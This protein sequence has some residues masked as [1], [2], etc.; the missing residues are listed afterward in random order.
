[1]G[2]SVDW[3]EGGHYRRVRGVAGLAMRGEEGVLGRRELAAVHQL[4]LLKDVSVPFGYCCVQNSVEVL[5]R[6]CRGDFRV[7]CI[8]PLQKLL[9][10]LVNVT[11]GRQDRGSLFLPWA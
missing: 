1:M 11:E 4:P 5:K 9:A 10:R 3:V 8:D 6:V 2:G 7:G